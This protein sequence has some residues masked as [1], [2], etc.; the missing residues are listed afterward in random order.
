MALVSAYECTP[1]SILLGVGTTVIEKKA[2]DWSQYSLALHLLQIEANTPI[3]NKIHDPL[4]NP[5]G[6]DVFLIN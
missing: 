3:Q 4:H 5:T 6:P 1:N 2:Q